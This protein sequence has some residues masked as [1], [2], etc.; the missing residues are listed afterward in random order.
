[1]Y[2][3]ERKRKRRE[4]KRK[5]RDKRRGSKAKGGEV[6]RRVE[7]KMNQNDCRIQNSSTNETVLG[8]D[9]VE[10]KG[11]KENEKEILLY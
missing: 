10:E 5:K 6:Q 3:I 11:S 4:E 8:R 2:G 7:E 1:M 9:E